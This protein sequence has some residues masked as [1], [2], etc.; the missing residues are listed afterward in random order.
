MTS[1]IQ[2]N[3]KYNVIINLFDGVFFGFAIGFVSFT[4]FLP[5][6]VATMT[7]S[8][9]LI[10][11]VPAVHNMGW[12]LPQLFT[13]K[14]VARLKILKPYVLINTIH[15]RL[16]F[17]FLA[18]VAWLIPTIGPTIALV[19]TF[20][21]LIW[22]GMG[23]GLAANGWQNLI[24]KIIPSDYLA[25]FFGLQSAA[26][27]LLASAGA[28]IAGSLLER[29]PGSRGF[30]YLFLIA[31]FFMLVS[32]FFLR[33]TREESTVRDENLRTDI[34]LWKTI[35]SVFRENKP[36]VWFIVSRI[37]FYFGMMA[38]A[39][40]IVYAVRK[41]RMSEI[42]AGILTSVL[43]ITQMAAN[44]ILGRIADKWSRKGVIEFG[45][46]ASVGC[47]LLAWLAPNTS[48]FY[49]VIILEGIANTAFWTIGFPILLEFGT[50]A[51]RP[52]FVGL[53]N[54]FIAPA[55]ILSPIL[56][57]WLADNASYP[58]TFLVSAILGGVA[59]FVLHF[60]VKDPKPRRR[61]AEAG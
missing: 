49:P 34:P 29:N 45:A 33:Q 42:E 21:M 37:L 8:A 19:L 30:S 35:G 3:L 5:L 6:F 52:T 38:Y 55:A 15:E 46:L 56:G 18:L 17:F 24:A 27:N 59:A 23:A 11:L 22:Q 28:I 2:R 39:F 43:L 32:W 57:G 31:S 48:W 61:S 7:D 4:T 26:A 51:Q 58:I 41:L 44:I 9:I 54:T 40:F 12:L 14:T 60:F 53:G 25:T 50:D 47:C 16:P 1:F 13:S 10:G 36:F 20:A